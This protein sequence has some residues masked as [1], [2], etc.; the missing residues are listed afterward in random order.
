MD[1]SIGRSA[2]RRA[3]ARVGVRS[4]S[5]HP[6]IK[7]G[8]ALARQGASAHPAIQLAQARASVRRDTGPSGN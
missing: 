2:A 5:A 1:R 4:V 3:Q 7:R 6:E 8:R